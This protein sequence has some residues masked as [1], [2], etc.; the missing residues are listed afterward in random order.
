MGR[1]HKRFSEIKRKL[2]EKFESGELK[3]KLVGVSLDNKVCE[4]DSK[5]LQSFT[6]ETINDFTY[7]QGVYGKRI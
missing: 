4:I 6:I 5:D 1:W 3:N 7:N 2:I